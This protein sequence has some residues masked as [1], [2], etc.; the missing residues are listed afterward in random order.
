MQSFLG[1]TLYDRWKAA[2]SPAVS[3]R[4]Q[5]QLVVEQP[6][7][8]HRALLPLLMAL[9][10][11]F[12]FASNALLSLLPFYLLGLSA[13]PDRFLLFYLNAVS[14]CRTTLASWRRGVGKEQHHGVCRMV[15]NML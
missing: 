1:Y 8:E 4:P 9:G 14:T 7:S 13:L 12:G 10:A 5:H 11:G 15:V 2:Q 6:S 3:G